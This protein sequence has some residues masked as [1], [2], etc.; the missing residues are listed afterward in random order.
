MA[1]PLFSLAAIVL[2]NVVI[3]NIKNNPIIS[4]RIVNAFELLIPSKV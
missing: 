2:P 4:V 3:V 1:P